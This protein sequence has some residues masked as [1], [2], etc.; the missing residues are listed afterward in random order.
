MQIFKYFLRYM[1]TKK[2]LSRWTVF[3]VG[4]LIVSVIY[5]SIYTFQF[6]DFSDLFINYQGGFIRRGLLGEIFYHFYLKG[7]NPVYLA[8]IISLLSYVVIVVYMIRNFRKHGYALEFLPISFLLG[9]VGIF[10]LAFFRR[11]F[12][13]MC[14]FLLIVKLWKS[15]PFRWW[16]LCG[17][18]L[19]ILAVLCHEPFAF[20]AFPLLLLI[21]R[22]KVR[23]LWKTI[24][25]WIPSMLVFLLCLHFSG[26]MEQY[27]LI[28]K[29]T[30]PFLEFPNVMDFLSYDKGYVMLFHLHY[31]FLDK[32]FHIPNIIG[33][34]VSIVLAI[35]MN[36]MINTV[37]CSFSDKNRQE[38]L[39]YSTLFLGIMVCLI[40]MFTILSTD[41]TR[42]IMYA[43]L[44]SYIVLF[45]L[46]EEDFNELL[47]S[48]LTGYVAHFLKWINRILPPSYTKIWVLLLC[49]GTVEWTGQGTFGLL[50]NSE[51]GNALLV[52]YKVS[53]KVISFL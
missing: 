49:V 42:I 27:L 17:N 15:L 51:I 20:W 9:G 43:S 39:C 41:Y 40:P 46:K 23:Y 7:I 26:S 35:Y 25:C 22:L 21:T 36:T 44:S 14:I 48:L 4:L 11:D 33:S 50:R 31:N 32:V 12:I 45:T 16:V 2:A 18:I 28:R 52:I 6:F 37:Y 10:G 1:N 47:P 8:Y 24:C 13:I 29:S 38:N 5:N 34:V 53:L 30:E 19:A 3:Y